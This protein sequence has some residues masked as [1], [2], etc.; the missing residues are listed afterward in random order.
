MSD[1]QLES[2]LNELMGDNDIVVDH[3]EDEAALLAAM[4]H[5]GDHD[6]APGWLCAQVY[7]NILRFLISILHHNQ[8]DMP[9][10][11]ADVQLDEA[12]LADPALNVCILFWLFC[13]ILVY[14]VLVV[15]FHRVFCFIASS[16]VTFLLNFLLFRSM[17]PTQHELAS[18]VGGGGAPRVS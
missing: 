12:D 14:F 4:A 18:L 2:E 9:D 13:F 3:D 15:L 16:I 6:A 5:D 10:D 7:V 1:D 11:A 8:D 17:Y